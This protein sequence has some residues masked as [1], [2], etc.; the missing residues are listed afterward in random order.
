MDALRKR[1]FK[2]EVDDLIRT[3]PGVRRRIRLGARATQKGVVLGFKQRRSHRLVDI[4]ECPVA[5][6]DIVDILPGL[7]V[8]LDECLEANA[9][10]EISVTAAES[11][12]DVVI[13]T[14]SPI[15]LSERERLAQWAE[16]ADLARLSWGGEPVVQRRA[17]RVTASGIEVDLPEGAFLQASQ[18][19]ALVLEKIVVAALQDAHSVADLHAGWGP[20]SLAL[21]AS[22][23]TVQ[24]YELDPAQIAA[25]AAAARRSGLGQ[26]I[27]AWERDLRYRPLLP[28]E[29]SGFDGLVLDPPRA[30]AAEQVIELAK[31]DIPVLAYVSCN[32]ASFAR[33]ARVLV[34]GGY[35]LDHVT[36]IDQF[37]W[38][39]HVELAGV[40]HR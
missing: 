20:F 24:A 10:A 2:I 33:D 17:V 39:P 8:V 40:F 13:D 32:P 35:S 18:E 9:A 3:S 21:A 34:E 7:R 14:K 6:A 16:E 22:G 4:A 1:G 37:P 23:K 29:L 19:G 36:P 31:S 11:G 12:L 38:S 27:F 5:R 15:E 30:G 26:K 28:D 25:L